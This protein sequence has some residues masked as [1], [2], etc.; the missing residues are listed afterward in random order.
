MAVTP[1]HSESV[2]STPNLGSLGDASADLDVLRVLANASE[3]SVDKIREWVRL[4][5][6]PM[7]NSLVDELNDLDVLIGEVRAKA[8]QAK[9]AVDEYSDQLIAEKHR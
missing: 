7:E 5:K 9:R 2:T 6:S 1:L 4:L 8:S 3:N